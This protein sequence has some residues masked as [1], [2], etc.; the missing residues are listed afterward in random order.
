MKHKRKCEET[1]TYKDNLKGYSSISNNI[2]GSG[3]SFYEDLC[4]N[5][6]FWLEL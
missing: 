3:R 1:S 6:F 4:Q 2:M 5:N